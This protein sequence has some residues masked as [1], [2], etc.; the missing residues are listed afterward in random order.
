MK[1]ETANHYPPPA[2]IMDEAH[3]KAKKMRHFSILFW[4]GDWGE[5]E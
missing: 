5:E 4:V 2:Q 3:A 1:N